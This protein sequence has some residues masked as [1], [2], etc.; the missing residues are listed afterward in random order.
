M[1]FFSNLT[2]GKSRRDARLATA[3][4]NKMLSAGKTA[5]LSALDAGMAQQ[6]G[7]LEGG[8]TSARGGMEDA[9]AK[10]LAALQG[11]AT[12]ARSDLEAGA[13]RAEGAITDALTRTNRVL[14]PYLQSGQRAQGLYDTALG[15][16]GADAAS[17][18][19]EQYAANDPF[20]QFNEDM[21]NRAMQRAANASG[22]FGSGRTA[23]AMSRA[24]LERGSADLNRYLDRLRDQG[25]QGGQVASQMAGYSNQA[26]TNIANL[27][28]SLGQNMANVATGLGTASANANMQ[29]GQQIGALDYGYGTDRGAIQAGNAG[30]RA[31]LE[32]GIAQQQAGNRIGLGNALASTR[33]T[34][35]NNLFQLGGMAIGAM[36]PGTYGVSA[37]GNLAG[38][39]RKTVGG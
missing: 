7:S 9:L 18:F 22:Q 37:A 31:N 33:S 29:S 5:A 10:A 20:R 14:D 26:G 34:G 32:Y 11:G 3:D 19:Y 25:T 6:L 15:V 16:N 17:S 39:L 38:G 12:T 27:R 35:L 30:N 21:Q 13:T 8:Y 24:N 2:G 1:G 23:M 4:A 28:N 36:T